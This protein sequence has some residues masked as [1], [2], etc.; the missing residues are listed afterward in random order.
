[1][2]KAH[3]ISQR[4]HLSLPRPLI[5]M[6]R[7]TTRQQCPGDIEDVVV[8]GAGLSGLSAGL[9]LLASGKHV[10]IVEADDIVGG[11]C[12]TET[13]ESAH[14][15]FEADTGAS[16]LTMSD[17]INVAI[18]AVGINPYELQLPDGRR[19]SV[20]KLSPAYTGQFASGRYLRMFADRDAMHK[21]LIRFA[22]DKYSC[23]A[24]DFRIRKLIEGYDQHRQWA[25]NMFTLSYEHFLASDFDGLL[26]LVSTPAATSSLG[27]LL[28]AGA[29]KHLGP[30]THK[31]IA[32]AEVE[33]M[34][35]FQALYA[36]EA[37]A[38]A[39]GVYSVISH[40]DCTM[41]V[42]YPEYS[43]G[44]A[45]EFMALAFQ[46]AGG[47]LRLGTQV[48]GLEL[49]GEH[50]RTVHIAGCEPLHPD[51]VISTV[52]IG[53]TANWVGKSSAL[54][55][56]RFSPSAV[57]LHGT[58]PTKV[59]DHW[60]HSQHHTLSF[61][62][63]W[64]ET[65]RRIT[66]KAGKGQLMMDPCLLITRPGQS[67]AHRIRTHQGVC[68]EPL[69][70]LAPTPNLKSAP[71][72]W[73]AIQ[74]GYIQELLLE[75][76][77]RGFTGLVDNFSIARVDTPQT[78]AEKYHY[79]DGSP[80]SLAHN[81]RQTGPFRPRN[82]PAFGIDNLVLAGCGT[83]PGVGI[84]TVLLSGALAARRITGGGVR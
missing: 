31:H 67:A 41:G 57:V 77:N 47:E 52:D 38:K 10:T 29:F 50:V 16:V 21:E 17:L 46:K 44:D 80:F 81:F 27:R 51:A 73:N 62:E 54:R 56:A 36:G 45:A 78:Y 71:V 74:E 34:L 15:P 68:Y 75:L 12:R 64:S 79:G 58:I 25:A 43:I 2:P 48:T 53:I 40:M 84:P 82:Y 66:A 28:A 11:R 19:W 32:D 8:V 61:G 26:D 42:Y 65:F 13:L 55:K 5:P 49:D 59:S 1:M 18:A 6:T 33:R 9:R 4:R 60:H 63:Q 24:D 7:A 30:T 20:R 76:E 22:Q 35:T 37:P 14:G 72:D 3:P 70:I 69:S 83:T 23:A 39:L